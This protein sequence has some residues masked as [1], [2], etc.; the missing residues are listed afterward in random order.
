MVVRCMIDSIR[1]ENTLLAA[2]LDGKN[3]RTK[4]NTSTKFRTGTPLQ[5]SHFGRK[6][7]HTCDLTALVWDML[8]ENCGHI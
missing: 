1:L 3:Y 5:K 7:L 6:F 2:H 4:R 8:E